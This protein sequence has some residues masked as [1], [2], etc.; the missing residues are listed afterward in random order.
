I[1]FLTGDVWK[2]TFRQAERQFQ[3]R[4][5]NRRK[6]PVGFPTTP[7]ISLLSGGLDSFVGAL[8]LL[9]KY[10]DQRLLFVSHY[11]RHVTG[12]ASDQ[13]RIRS[14]LAGKFVGRINQLQ[15]RIGVVEADEDDIEQSGKHDFE[16]SFR[17]RSLFFL[18]LGV[19]AAARVGDDV[20]IIIPENGP[21]AL[22][23]P[24]NPSRRGSCS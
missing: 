20:P 11:D 24:L 2:L 23:L 19:Y 22:N 15:V 17:S 9:K 16:R 21:V 14:F 5:K 7:V 18:G 12:P 10:P 8:N 1:S 3:Q 4:R 6:S 13:D